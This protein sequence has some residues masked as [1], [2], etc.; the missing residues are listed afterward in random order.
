M[1]YHNDLQIIFYVAFYCFIKLISNK[2]I[3]QF[4]IH[5]PIYPQITE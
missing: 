2:S 4:F 3:E 1:V 5:I